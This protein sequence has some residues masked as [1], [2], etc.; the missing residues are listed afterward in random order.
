MSTNCH[1]IEDPLAILFESLASTERRRLFRTIF[2][3][4][5]ASRTQVE[6]ATALATWN[7]ENPQNRVIKQTRQ[8][9]LRDLH[10][11][12][13]PKLES[14]ELIEQ[15]DDD[16]IP[17]TD[18]PAFDDVGIRDAIA[19]NE[20]S[21]LRDALFRA[22][23]SAH[24]RA[25]LN[26]LSHQCQ[27]IHVETLAREIVDIEQGV[28]E[29]EVDSA[30]V[31]SLTTLYY[32]THLP[33]LSEA[34]LIEYDVEKQTVAYSGHPLL[35]VPWMHSQL[36]PDFRVSLTVSSKDEDVWTLK[37]R[38][39]IVSY[40]QSL[41]EEADEEL[42]LMLTTTGLLEAGCFAR[43]DQ[44][45][46]R[47]VDVYI[48]TRDPTI[49][50][51]VENNVPEVTLWEPEANWLNFPVEEENVGRLLFADRKSVLLGT[52]GKEIEEGI[53]EEQAVAGEGVDNALV[54]LLRQMLS[55]QL[56]QFSKDD[57]SLESKLPF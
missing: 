49:R 53:Y 3:E 56:E 33:I 30:D 57:E 18:H 29:Q 4:A 32:H 55:P 38:E 20:E 15:D 24:R 28:H 16:V 42:F 39:N 7:N 6:L 19:E 51:Y 14:A 45:I 26:V 31:D 22:L 37:G 43:V 52:L 21:Q 13:L 44:A 2:E 50:D 48:G 40:G 47:G 11:I 27:P 23:T 25:I 46:D 9:A 10:H 36:S 17:V 5:P 54:V 35:R 12:H 8:D 34:E 1:R 41:C